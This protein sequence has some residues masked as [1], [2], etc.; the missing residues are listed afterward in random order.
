MPTSRPQRRTVITLW[1]FPYFDL[2]SDGL[3][4]SIA[5]PREWIGWDDEARIRVADLLPD[6]EGT[7]PPVPWNRMPGEALA[8]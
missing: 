1:Y 7:A 8:Y 3:R 2:L 5:R 6:Y 4:A